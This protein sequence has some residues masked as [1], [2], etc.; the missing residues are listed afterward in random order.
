MRYGRSDPD[1]PIPGSVGDL[2]V[3]DFWAWGYSNVLTNNLQGVFA[4]TQAAQ[5]GFRH[6]TDA[7]PESKPKGPLL[8]TSDRTGWTLA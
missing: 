7:A 5:A 2:T 6:R 8:E 3:G 1:M 4:E